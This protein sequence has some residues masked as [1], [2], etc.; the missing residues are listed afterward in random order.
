MRLAICAFGASPLACSSSTF[1]SSSLETVERNAEPSIK[2]QETNCMAAAVIQ[3]VG[4][5]MFEGLKI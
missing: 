4:P 5:E 1:S 3:Q 2:P